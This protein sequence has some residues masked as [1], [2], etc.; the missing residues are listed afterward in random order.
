MRH[1]ATLAFVTVIGVLLGTAVARAEPGPYDG[2]GPGVA[3]IGGALDSGDD[4]LVVEKLA[5]GTIVR[6]AYPGDGAGVSRE[7]A[8]EDIASLITSDPSARDSIGSGRYRLIAVWIPA[9]A[10]NEV[11]LVGSGIGPGG[12]RITTV[13]G[14]QREGAT[15]TSYGR[16][17][18]TDALLVQFASQGELRMTG[19]ES[20]GAPSTGSGDAATG[21]PPGSAF[22]VFGAG[23]AASGAI[24]YVLLRRRCSATS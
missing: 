19:T 9:N 12:V 5:D 11:Y 20:P 3:T 24:L 1:P 15:I 18:D 16:A 8:A 2:L 4:G 23:M 7:E 6:T 13:F 22:A 17:L 14:T 21:G 10:P